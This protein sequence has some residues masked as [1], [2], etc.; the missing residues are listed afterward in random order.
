[1]VESHQSRR[2]TSL[3]RGC[4]ADS[5]CFTVYIFI[6]SEGHANSGELITACSSPVSAAQ[7]RSAGPMRTSPC[8]REFVAPPSVAMWAEAQG[9]PPATLGNLSSRRTGSSE[10][11]QHCWMMRMS[12]ARTRQR[13]GIRGIPFPAVFASSWRTW[14]EA[15]VFEPLMKDGSRGQYWQGDGQTHR[16]RTSH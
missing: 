14:L 13:R 11:Y 7:P 16:C 10:Q 4:V 9:S 3:A 12:R 6:T 1:M 8:V 5:C 2:W 15:G